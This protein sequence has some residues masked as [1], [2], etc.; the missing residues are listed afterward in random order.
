MID[1]SDWHRIDDL[2]R[3]RVIGSHDDKRI[4]MMLGIFESHRDSLVERDR[5]T[6]LPTW[7]LRVILFVDRGAFH[8]QEK[9]GLIGMWPITSPAEVVVIVV[10]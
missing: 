8:L 2:A 10:E 4:R 3:V 5:L 6:N 7:I 9:A 1:T